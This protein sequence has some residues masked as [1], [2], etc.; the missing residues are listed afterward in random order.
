M[1]GVVG[2]VV[3]VASLVLGAVVTALG[4]EVL[5]PALSESPPQAATVSDTA[6]RLAVALTR[7]RRRRM[8]GSSVR[9]W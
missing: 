3:A 8:S 2:A 1:A 4:V 9:I 7:I 6:A 5:D